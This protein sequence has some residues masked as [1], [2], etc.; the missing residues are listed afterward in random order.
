MRSSF[1]LKA[2]RSITAPT[3]LRV[4]FVAIFSMPS[5]TVS[6]STA[7]VGMLVCLGPRRPRFLLTLTFT[8][9]IASLAAIVASSSCPFSMLKLKSFLASKRSSSIWLLRSIV[10]DLSLLLACMS[11]LASSAFNARP[12]SSNLNFI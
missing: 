2:M 4:F 7:N 5:S 3:L 10:S 12:F 9:S 1:L 8:G 6:F 11:D